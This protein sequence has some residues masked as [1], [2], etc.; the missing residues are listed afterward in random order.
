[1]KKLLLFIFTISFLSSLVIAQ[2]KSD[3]AKTKDKS[4]DKTEKTKN[5]QAENDKKHDQAVW[6]GTTNQGGGAKASKNQPAKVRAAFQR[7]YPNAVNVRW[8]KYRGDW[9]ATFGNGLLTS[10]AV[11]H[12]NGDRRDTRT[13]V[14]QS[15]LP[16][17]IFKDIFKGT[18]KTQLGDIIKIE[19]PQTLKDIFRVKTTTD[20]VSRF[21]FYNSDGVIV[22][23]DY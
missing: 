23:Y 2:G 1:M 11:Y 20:G 3:K 9:T 17:I 13:P 18:P 22:Q 7:D 8:S 19:V 14:P 15:Q 5:S 4:K 16:Q 21:V 6:E 10:T 12:A